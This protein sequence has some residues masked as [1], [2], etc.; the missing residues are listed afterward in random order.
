MPYKF[1]K[2]RYLYFIYRVVSLGFLCNHHHH[3]ITEKFESITLNVCSFFFTALVYEH[4]SS[5]IS[6]QC[7]F[8][9]DNR[10]GISNELLYL[11]FSK[12][13]KHY[14]LLSEKTVWPYP[15]RI[16]WVEY[17]PYVH[18]D[19]GDLPV[20]ML[21]AVVYRITKTCIKLEGGVTI[22]ESKD[23]KTH[24]EDILEVI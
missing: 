4:C 8:N 20:G 19:S 23:M 1:P 21:G 7:L 15:F 13:N 5:R 9:Y 2:L 10:I 14:F 12:D 11:F 6:I 18:S 17:H 22:Q 24:R 16:S 3:H